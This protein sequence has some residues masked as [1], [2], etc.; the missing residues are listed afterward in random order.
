L[1]SH[2]YDQPIHQSI[3]HTDIFPDNVMCDNGN[4]TLV[5]FEE[6]CQGFSMIDIG[7]VLMACCIRNNEL[8]VSLAR[9]FLQGYN[10]IRPL[11]ELEFSL[12]PSKYF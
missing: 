12:I 3:I 9:S 1:K 8:D 4:V 7:I 6:M 10:S 11:S 5:D 2:L